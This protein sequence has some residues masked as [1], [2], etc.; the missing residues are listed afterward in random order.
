MARSRQ[1]CRIQGQCEQIGFDGLADI[2][3]DFGVIGLGID[4]SEPGFVHFLLTRLVG[5]TSFL[6]FKANFLFA[7]FVS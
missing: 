5:F 4:E 6:R 7:R 3:V 2:V 1:Q